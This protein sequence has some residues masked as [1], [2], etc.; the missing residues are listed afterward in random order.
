MDVSGFLDRLP[1]A[2]TIYYFTTVPMDGDIDDIVKPTM[3][4]LV[5][6]AYL[7]DKDVE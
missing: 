7:N 3:D 2:V 4:A 5:F 6:V 1:L